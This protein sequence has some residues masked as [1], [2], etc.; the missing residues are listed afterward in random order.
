[1][2]LLAYERIRPHIDNQLVLY[3]AQL[4]AIIAEANRDHKARS[5]PFSLSDFII[6][7]RRK[8][9]AVMQEADIEAF[10][11]ALAGAKH[12][13]DSDARGESQRGRDGVR[14]GD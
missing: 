14:Q 10:F 1:M 13:N 6:D 5:E 9:R 3:L 2:E 11:R 4:A 8:R 7:F 12:G